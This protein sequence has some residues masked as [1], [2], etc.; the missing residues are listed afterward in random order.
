ME[1]YLY[2]AIKVSSSNKPNHLSDDSIYFE[3]LMIRSRAKRFKNALNSFVLSIMNKVVEP[4]DEDIK[5]VSLILYS[6]DGIGNS[7]D[8]CPRILAYGCV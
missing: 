1:V 3:G 7:S 6:E 2:D 5:L 8:T 4:Q